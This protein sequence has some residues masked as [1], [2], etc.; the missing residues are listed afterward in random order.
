VLPKDV[1]VDDVKP[2]PGF[3]LNISGAVATGAPDTPF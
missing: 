2:T 3:F 1:T